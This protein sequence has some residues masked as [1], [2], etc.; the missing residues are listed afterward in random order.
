MEKMGS[1]PILVICIHG[2]WMNG[3]EMALVRRRLQRRHGFP[4]TQ[5]SYHTVTEGMAEN[6]RRLSRFIDQLPADTVHLVGHSLG[7]VL[8]MQM[9]KRFPTD[10]VGRVVCLGSPLVDSIAARHLDRRAWGH[11]ILG[12]TMRD[13]VL[14]NPLRT[15]DASHEVGVIGGTLGLGLGLFVARLEA[16]HDG[17]VTQKETE[18]P[19][20]TDHLML[21][22]DHFGLI[23][24]RRVVDQTAHFL[25]HGRFDHGL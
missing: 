1:D 10:K 8:A 6:T 2:L 20:L 25:C 16:P 23:L 9:L 7:G 18:L 22:V 14:E 3:M 24:S 13:A 12:K 5:F 21:S 15:A 11:K 4:T 19:G 17:V